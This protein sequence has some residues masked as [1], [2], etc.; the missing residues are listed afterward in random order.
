MTVELRDTQKL[1]FTRVTIFSNLTIKIC[2][3]QGVFFSFLNLLF[4]NFINEYSIFRSYLSL[5]LSVTLSFGF[6]LFLISVIF[7][8]HIYMV[9]GL[10][11]AVW[12]MP[13]GSHA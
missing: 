12:S 11:V 2:Y 4:G 5:N 6:P 10:L 3:R 9:I 13:H 1:E 8:A 7:S